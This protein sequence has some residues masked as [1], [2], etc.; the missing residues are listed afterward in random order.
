MNVRVKTLLTCGILLVMMTMVVACQPEADA[1][2]EGP[3]R[4]GASLSLSGRFEGPGS[5]NKNGY[6]A[7][8]TIVNEAGGLLGRQVELI[9]L[10]NESDADKAVAQYEALITKDKVDL[11]VGPFSSFLVIPTSAVAAEHGYAFVEPAGGAPEVFNRGLNNIFFAQ[12]APS[13][14]QADPFVTYLLGLGDEERPKTFAIVTQE[15][16][17]TQSVM[18]RFKNVLTGAELELVLEEVYPAEQ[19]D[20][21]DIA[22][23]VAELDPDV[24]IGGTL[25]EDSVGQIEAY[26][27]ADYQPRFA[28]FTSGPSVAQLFRSS[29]GDA[30]EGVFSSI[31]WFPEAKEHQNQQFVEQHVDM[32]GGTLG[33]ISEDAANAF[34]VGQ[35]LQQAIENAESIDNEVLIEE[36]HQGTYKTVV[37]TLSFDSTGSPLGSYMLL[38]WQGDNFVIVGPT[39]RAE[40]NPLLPPKPEW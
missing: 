1:V 9:I 38:Q 30:T 22:E 39:D 12:P 40:T 21:S 34:T 36:L 18:D 23:Q 5:A 28:F 16:A 7:W 3:I 29:L 17:F 33:D 10:D 2:E 35:V 4:I 13:V 20:F 19:T 15:D 8:A 25:F 14:R 37:G 32:F 11:V 27:A 24:I 26:Q 31:S 6:E